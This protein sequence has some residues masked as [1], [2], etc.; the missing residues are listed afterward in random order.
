MDRRSSPQGY[1]PRGRGSRDIESAP[2]LPTTFQEAFPPVT[3]TVRP[4]KRRYFFLVFVICVLFVSLRFMSNQPDAKEDESLRQAFPED[5]ASKDEDWSLVGTGTPTWKEL[6]PPQ[7]W[8]IDLEDKSQTVFENLVDFQS[9]K[10]GG[11]STTVWKEEIQKVD[12]SGCQIMDHYI[13]TGKIAII[14]ADDRICDL[15]T[16]AT[17]AEKAG[18]KAILFY[19]YSTEDALLSTPLLPQSWK[20]GDSLISIPVLTITRTLAI[21]LLEDQSNIRLT[22]ITSTL[23]ENLVEAANDEEPKN[24]GI[25][26]GI[27]ESI[28]KFW[29]GVTNALT[30]PFRAIRDMWNSLWGKTPKEGDNDSD[31]DKGPDNDN[32]DDKDEDKNPDNGD[33]KDEDKDPG[34]DGD[35]DDKDEDENPGNDGDKDEDKD[36]GNDGDKDEDKDPGNDEDKSPDNGDDNDNDKNPD[37]D[38]PIEGILDRIKAAFG[39]LWDGIVGFLTAPWVWIKTV[40]NKIALHWPCVKAVLMYGFLGAILGALVLPVALYLIAVL[41]GFGPFGVI[42]GSIA[43]VWMALHGGFIAAGSIYAF[44]Q[45]FGALG[46]LAAFS[47]LTPF[48]I[49]SGCGIGIYYAIVTLGSC[50]A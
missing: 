44:F 12:D 45:S 16:A 17:H 1:F 14:K 38:S 36:P 4:V 21:T 11:P 39:L 13:A 22:L 25:I 20:Q 40:W 6:Q 3:K 18:V 5:S 48:G 15:W 10:Y 29:D 8:R 49:F 50:S 41:I 37:S 2:L 26:D 46:L 43:A 42:A 34:N 28:R 32:G 47:L 19:S 24:V 33:D 27:G 7:L 35:R 9:L 30:S 31:K 23:A